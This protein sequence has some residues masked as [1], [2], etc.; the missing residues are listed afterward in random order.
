MYQALSS[1][2]GDA[3]AWK[4]TGQPVVRQQRGRW[5]VRVDGI[6]TE[7]GKVR[8]RQLGTFASRR[9]AQAA[10]TK[11]A[12]TA[13]VGRVRGTVGWLVERWVASRT[14]VGSKAREQYGWAAGHIQVGIGA[15]PL[16]RL[17]RED[18]AGW[19][20]GLAAGGKLSRRSIQIFRTVLR[21]S[22]RDAVEEGL[23]PRSPA[24]RVP[25]P[26]E[27]TRPTRAREVEAWT[28]EEVTRFLSVSNG[29]RWAAVWRLAVLY[30]PRRSE[31]LALRWDD[32]DVEARTVT[33]DEGLVG[34]ID[35]V[36]WTEGKTARSRRMIP[37]DER[38]A[39][40][41]AQRRV[42]QLEERLLAGPLWEGLDL[43]VTTRTGGFVLPR[44]FDH[45]L[46]RLVARAEVP[47]LSSHGL[48]HTAATH[49]VREA[50]DVGELRAVADVLGH[51][52]DMLMKVYAHRMPDSLRAVA[53]RIGQR[54][55]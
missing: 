42:E 16:E 43:V 50:R 2:E 8:P 46:A 28:D 6:D 27:V 52:P 32:I 21:A 54:A 22:L 47:K 30:G 7:T 34:L 45:T 37:V 24:A 20:D 33:I 9:A 48:R 17:D 51:S 29:H 40:L 10:A 39:R 31:L 53:E 25:M 55:D 38:T 12:R 44:N 18:V 3:M 41:F 26:R 5:V 35:G 49:M 1:T 13:S 23:L 11:A 36:A 19:L 4:A 15:I 14:D